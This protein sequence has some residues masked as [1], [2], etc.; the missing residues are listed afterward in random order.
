MVIVV[1]LP[2]V[3]S[4]SSVRDV[5]RADV[6]DLGTLAPPGI[7][8]AAAVCTDNLVIHRPGWTVMRT[9][10]MSVYRR[11]CSSSLE[12]GINPDRPSASGFCII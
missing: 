2:V 4:S 3:L 12:K 8:A 9:I 7:E 10:S 6:T 5:L 1:P 11:V